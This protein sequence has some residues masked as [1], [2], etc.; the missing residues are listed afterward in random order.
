MKRNALKKAMMSEYMGSMAEEK[1]SSKKDKTKHEK[2]ESKKM[3]MKEKMM[4]KFKKK[5]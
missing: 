1:Y 5:K 3:E 4:S 2:G